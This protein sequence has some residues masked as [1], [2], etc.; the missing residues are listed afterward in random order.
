M[1]ALPPLP[2][3]RFR[4]LFYIALGI[5]L[6]VVLLGIA[7]A[8]LPPDIRP[9]DDPAPIHF[10]AVILEGS[11]RAIEPWY[12]WDA[13]WYANV[14]ENGYFEAKDK[15]GKLGPAFLPALPICMAAASAAGLNPYWV[16]LL[17]A[18]VAAAAGSASFARIAARVSG[19]SQTGMRSFVLLF[20]FPTSFFFSAPYNESFGLL[21]TTLALDAW[22]QLRPSRAGAFAFLGS[23]SRMSGIAL[24]AA[25]LGA[26]LLEDRSRAGLRRASILALGSF[27]G[28]IAFWCYIGWVFDDPFASLK[29][30]QAWG[31]KGLSIWNP[32]LSI[33][34]IYD[35]VVPHWGEGLAALAFAILGIRA[36]WKRGAFCGILTLLPIVQ[37]MA[38]GTLLSGHRIVLAALPGFI[39]MADLLKHRLAYRTTI[40]VFTCIQFQLLNRYVHWQFAG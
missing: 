23:L 19:N 3:P 20:A 6:A 25:A 9:G 27:V 40:V 2:F 8:S 13:V 31:R 21:F 14:A 37:M 33:Q 30:Q 7:L 38:T 39:E 22:L 15:G 24:G 29:T 26:W 28:L 1:D 16:A 12:R 11:A 4:V 18:N 32:W 34:S 17:L 35:P 10:R 36:W 5:R